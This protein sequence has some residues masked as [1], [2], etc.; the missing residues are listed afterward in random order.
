MKI[1]VKPFHLWY[2]KDKI[3]TSGFLLPAYCDAD[4]K[5]NIVRS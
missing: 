1:P 2:I 3:S 4:K 5:G